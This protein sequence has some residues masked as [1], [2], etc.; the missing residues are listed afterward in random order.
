MALEVE[1][2]DTVDVF[3]EIVVVEAVVVFLGEILVVVLIIGVVPV[4]PALAQSIQRSSPQH[5][6][7]I[8]IRSMMSLDFSLFLY[9]TI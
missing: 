9:S 5:S 4:N 1:T 8:C 3:L 6:Y 2:V 7:F